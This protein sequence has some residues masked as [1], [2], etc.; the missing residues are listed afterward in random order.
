MRAM[1]HEQMFLDLNKDG[2]FIPGVMPPKGSYKTFRQAFEEKIDKE[3]NDFTHIDYRVGD[4][5]PRGGLLG[6]IAETAGDIYSGRDSRMDRRFF[7]KLRDIVFSGVNILPYGFDQTLPEKGQPV[8]IGEF[9]LASYDNGEH[10][11]V[12]KSGYRYSAEMDVFYMLALKI[13]ED[14]VWS[15]PGWYQLRGIQDIEEEL[16]NGKPGLFAGKRE[17]ERFAK[18]RKKAEEEIMKLKEEYVKSGISVNHHLFQI[19]LVRLWTLNVCPTAKREDKKIR[20]ALLEALDGH[21]ERLLKA[22][23]MIT[24]AER[25]LGIENDSFFPYESP[26]TRKAGIGQDEDWDDAD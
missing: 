14:N 3:L 2:Q 4:H 17:R 11:K 23:E 5:A 21:E 26:S 20:K 15:T 24:A 7:D 19:R 18:K 22:V 9:P 6:N 13:T 25:E 10:T 16:K 1:T 8:Y 12:D